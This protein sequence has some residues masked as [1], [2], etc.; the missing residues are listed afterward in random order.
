MDGNVDEERLREVASRIL[1]TEFPDYVLYDGEPPEHPS[2]L[3]PIDFESPS[4]DELTEH[5]RT[6]RTSTDAATADPRSNE[7]RTYRIHLRNSP[8]N[9][10][11]AAVFAFWT[12]NDEI[13]GALVCYET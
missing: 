4:A 10:S 7:A 12:E 1:S 13:S 5:Y 3:S 8:D 6:Q 11:Q 9:Y 2:E